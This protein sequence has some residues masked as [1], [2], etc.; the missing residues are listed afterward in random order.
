MST[1]ERLNVSFSLSP[2]ICDYVRVRE[3]LT[4]F[5]TIQENIFKARLKLEQ[6]IID[7]HNRSI[8]V[9]N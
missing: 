9:L 2:H 7:F 8:V 3:V 1:W 5:Y 4:L 6:I